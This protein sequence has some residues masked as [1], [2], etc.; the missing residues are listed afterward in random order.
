MGETL[1][2]VIL[3]I[4]QQK[5]K[6]DYRK[7][8][9]V[10]NVIAYILRKDKRKRDDIWGSF[11]VYS[12]SASGMAADFDKLKCL[13]GK[14]DGLQLKHLVLSW[15]GRPDMSRKKLR[16]KI[17]RTMGFW[18]KSYQLVYAV[19]EDRLPESWHIHIVLN[20]VSNTGKKIQI[21]SKNLKKFMRSFNKIWN[22]YGYEL[23]AAPQ[24]KES[25]EDK[26]FECG[27]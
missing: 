10:K 9:D 21:T 7:P 20:S 15:G 23:C 18:G 3:K 19:H 13:Y 24:K 27:E 14:S 12:E 8:D 6:D 1:N 25:A 2:P 11:G 16:K 4:C 22:P 26:S 17:K 5:K